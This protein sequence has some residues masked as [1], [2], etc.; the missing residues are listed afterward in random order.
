MDDL[1]S[2]V[3][4][5]RGCAILA[6]LLVAV[7]L[8][9]EVVVISS[10]N[11][12]Y[13]ID[14]SFSG[15]SANYTIEVSGSDV[16]DAVLFDRNGT[17]PVSELTIFVDERYGEF[18]D[19]AEELVYYIDQ[20]Y[21]A[22]QFAVSLSNRGFDSVNTCNSDGL[23]EYLERT[24]SNPSGCGLFVT[25]YALPS[26]V[27]SGSADD[28]LYRWIAAGGT[29]YWMGSEIGRYYV[30]EDTLIEVENR[31]PL[32]PEDAHVNRSGPRFATSVVDNG[33]TDALTLSGSDLL[34]AL[35]VTN[36]P[37]AKSLG[38]Q[39]EGY[40]TISMLPC[41]Q[42]EVCVFAGDFDIDL[43]DDVGQIVAAGI[44]CDT[45]ICEHQSGKVVKG[46]VNGTLQGLGEYSTVYIYIGGMYV[47]FGGAFHV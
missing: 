37:N 17:E 10:D 40:S 39:A 34:Y 9:G 5:R 16:Y 12:S 33:F 22:Q 14:V 7:V 1:T 13:G 26:S 36:V 27:Y 47:R 46:A 23:F 42:G 11:S 21:T 6:I 8:V 3:F 41:G 15:E 29:L 19:Q 30:D 2:K 18:F 35:D 20:K 32:L 38:Y 24:V 44:S 25:S 28:L 45:V 43:I 31:S 4:G